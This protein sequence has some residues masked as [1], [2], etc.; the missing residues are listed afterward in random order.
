MAVAAQSQPIYVHMYAYILTISSTQNEVTLA[1]NTNELC[2]I[3]M[4]TDHERKKQAR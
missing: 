3:Q 1:T 2:L 4:V